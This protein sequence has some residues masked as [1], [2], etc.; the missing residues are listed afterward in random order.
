MFDT[1]EINLLKI[2]KN[3]HIKIKKKNYL[4]IILAN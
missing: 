4:I 3:L 2:K 1:R